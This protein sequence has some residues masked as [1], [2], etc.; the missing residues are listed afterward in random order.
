[1][2]TIKL[3]WSRLLAFDQ[4]AAAETA[5]IADPRRLGTKIGGKSGDKPNGIQAAPTAR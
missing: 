2:T 3:D 5:P 1:M 4:A